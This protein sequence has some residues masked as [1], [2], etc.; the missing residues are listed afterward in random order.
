MP[1]I[2]RGLEDQNSRVRAKVAITVA[3]L[4][5]LGRGAAP[6]LA[7]I[8]SDDQEPPHVREAARLALNAIHPSVKP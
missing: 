6:D 3:Q 4:G 1:L 8:L 2:L 7:R 5:P